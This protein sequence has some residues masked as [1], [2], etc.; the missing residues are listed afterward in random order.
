[1]HSNKN[2]QS[3]GNNG[4]KAMITVLVMQ[5]IISILKGALREGLFVP[6]LALSKIPPIFKRN[7]LQTKNSEIRKLES[8][9]H[10]QA[11]NHCYFVSIFKLPPLLEKFID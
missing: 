1:M 11:D 3:I 4:F 8:E 10:N 7:D 5:T 6:N 2:S 9:W